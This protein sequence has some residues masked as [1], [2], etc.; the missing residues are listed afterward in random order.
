MVSSTLSIPTKTLILGEVEWNI[1]RDIFSIAKLGGQLGH[2]FH[3]SSEISKFLLKT[4]PSIAAP[5]FTRQIHIRKIIQEPKITHFQLSFPS[6]SP[7][8]Q[9]VTRGKRSFIFTSPPWIR[10]GEMAPQVYLGCPPEGIR[11]E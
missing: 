5:F 6:L 8:K 2:L 10:L 4:W 1:I 9:V 7:S 11:V 3:S